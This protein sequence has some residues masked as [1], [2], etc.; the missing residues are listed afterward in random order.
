MVLQSQKIFKVLRFLLL[1]AEFSS[2]EVLSI[3]ALT[4]N[5]QE[6]TFPWMSLILLSFFF[7]V[8]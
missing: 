8:C 6:S 4:N 5:M 2:R 3:Y 7:N 1:I